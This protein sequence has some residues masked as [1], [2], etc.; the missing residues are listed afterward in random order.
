MNRCE[1][2]YCGHADTPPCKTCPKTQST[3]GWVDP[4][5]RL[6]I[7]GEN[8]L[9]YWRNETHDKNYYDISHLLYDGTFMTL[10]S[11]KKPWIKVL[12]WMPLPQPPYKE[13]EI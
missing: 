2:C 8:V 7:V 12:A 3:S 1:D 13:D 5:D 11:Y 4:K 9:V 10:D 6:P